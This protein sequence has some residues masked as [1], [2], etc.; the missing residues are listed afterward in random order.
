VPSCA[1]LLDGTTKTSPPHGARGC[2]EAGPHPGRQRLAGARPQQRR[3]PRLRAAAQAGHAYLHTIVDDH[4]RLAYA[5]QHRDEAAAIAADF[6]KRAVILFNAQGIDH[7]HRVPG[8]SGWAYR[9]RVFNPAPDGASGA[10]LGRGRRA[11][12]GRV[13]IGEE[14]PGA[15][16][17][18]ELGMAG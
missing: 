3:A 11:L 14:H 2:Q 4:F 13:R 18:R 9:S 15:S 10:A 8:D 17:Q 16:V 1:D 5:E 6:C 7:I 12:P